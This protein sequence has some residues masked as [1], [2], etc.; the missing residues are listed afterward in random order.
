[1]ARKDETKRREAQAIRTGTLQLPGARLV[2]I[3]AAHPRI[4]IGR[5]PSCDVVLDDL[6]ASAIHAEIRA[7]PDGV[8]LRDLGS[9]NGT[10]VG[11]ARLREG[12]LVAAC[13]LQ[14]GS[15]V[16]RFEPGPRDQLEISREEHLDGLWGRSSRMRRLFNQICEIAPTERSVLVTGETGT[17]KELV[18]RALHDHSRRA[19][20][21][22]A[23]VDC[24]SLAP[25]L[26]E[27]ELFGHEKGAFTGALAR[28]DGSFREAEGGTLFLDEIGELPMDGQRVLLRALAEK[29]VRRVGS[30]KYDDVN[31]RVVAATH[32][33]LGRLTNA[34]RFREDLFFRIA[35]IKIELVPLR[36]RRD[37]I[38]LLIRA[39]CERIGKS[40]RAD[41]MIKLVTGRFEQHEWPGNVRE[42]FGF[43]CAAAELPPGAETLDEMLSAVKD[44]GPIS[45]TGDFGR[46]RR[47]LIAAFE[48]D[49]FVRL[50]KDT[51]GNVSEMARRSGL[52]R[53]HVRRYLKRYAIRSGNG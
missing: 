19:K 20:G 37:D 36:E 2:E 7:E 47:E 1:M 34:G 12:A 45:S 30:T 18:S 49:Y 8:L 41:E 14:I 27:S 52:E 25:T 50:E 51:S 42:L 33:D 21:P 5:D 48:R 17:G 13:T 24:A 46:S 29:K 22:F 40:E 15:T 39:A 16:L 38:P 32:Q 3:A 53:H 6:E 35:Q 26:I 28:T 10:I 11:G 9:K 31:V 44:P 4:L 43:V 23:V